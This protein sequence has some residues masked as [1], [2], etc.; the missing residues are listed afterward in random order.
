[1]RVWRVRMRSG[2]C[3]PLANVPAVIHARTIKHIDDRLRTRTWTQHSTHGG[4]MIAQAG[5]QGLDIRHVHVIS[6]RDVSICRSRIHTYTYM[7]AHATHTFT[8]THTEAHAFYLM[9]KHIRTRTHALKHTW[10]N[11]RF[12]AACALLHDMSTRSRGPRSEHIMLG[13]TTLQHRRIL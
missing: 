4:S 5:Y 13:C 8:R 11:R 1:V 9:H 2:C 12:M 7:Y 3:F 6:M 10:V